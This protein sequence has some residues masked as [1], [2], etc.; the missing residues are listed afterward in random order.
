MANLD[1]QMKSS[2]SVE[3]V[4]SQMPSEPVQETPEPVQEVSNSVSEYTSAGALQESDGTSIQSEAEAPQETTRK[5]K[6]GLF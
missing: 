5:K 2:N 3:D 6:R 4:Q 1:Q